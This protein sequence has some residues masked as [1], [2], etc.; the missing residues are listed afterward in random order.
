VISEDEI[1]RLALALP[2]AYEDIHRG[3]PAFRVEKRIFA[4]LRHEQP[5][6]PAHL[7]VKL[8]SDD[9]HNLLEGYPDAV[10]PGVHYP[11]H[12]WTRVWPDEADAALVALILLLAWLHVTPKRLHGRLG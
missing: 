1:R 7:I 11:H 6:V 2:E 10:V 3:H 8:G 9:Q 12:G 4:M 5:G